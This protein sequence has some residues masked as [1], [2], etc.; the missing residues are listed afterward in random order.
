[1]LKKIKKA[2]HRSREN[3]HYIYISTK[4]FYLNY[5]KNSHNSLNQTTLG[6]FCF[7]NGQK[8]WTES[9]KKGMTLRKCKVKLQ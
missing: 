2:S 3:I 4:D 8:T 6:F 1:M 9:S 7:F 5:I